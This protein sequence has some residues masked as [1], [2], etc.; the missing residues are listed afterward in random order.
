ML[1]TLQII[2]TDLLL[3]AQRT[4]KGEVRN[5]ISTAMNKILLLITVEVKKCQE[6]P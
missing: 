1:K 3:S 5:R 6:T 4:V 2:F